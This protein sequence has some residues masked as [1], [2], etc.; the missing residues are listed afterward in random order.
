MRKLT[1]VLVVLGQPA[2]GVVK[3]VAGTTKAK[4][5][6]MLQKSVASGNRKVGAAGVKKAVPAG[7]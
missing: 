7:I 4:P 2:S 1:A 3:R 5:L 6:V